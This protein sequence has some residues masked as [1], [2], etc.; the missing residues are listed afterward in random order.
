MQLALRQCVGEGLERGVRND[1][2]DDLLEQ[3]ANDDKVRN[4]GA[5]A[6]AEH[7]ERDYDTP[8]VLER[9]ES[10]IEVRRRRG[11]AVRG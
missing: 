9:E 1:R 11:A 4:E 7:D 2:R 5:E 8:L 6:E 3:C 10:D